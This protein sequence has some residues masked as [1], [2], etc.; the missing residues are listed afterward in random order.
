MV[1]DQTISVCDPL[2]KIQSREQQINRKFIWKESKSHVKILI[3]SYYENHMAFEVATYF[4]PT[5]ESSASGFFRHIVGM[6]AGAAPKHNNSLGQPTLIANQAHPAT[7]LSLP[8]SLSSVWNN[9]WRR[10]KRIT[11]LL[12]HRFSQYPL[13]SRLLFLAFLSLRR[14]GE[15]GFYHLPRIICFTIF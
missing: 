10:F 6:G 2:E 4:L 5:V 8:G 9:P 7:S 1:T 11:D 13:S 15:N 3:T 14:F 12:F